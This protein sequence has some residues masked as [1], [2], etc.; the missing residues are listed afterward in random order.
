M[1]IL[2][3]TDHLLLNY[4]KDYGIGDFM[5]RLRQRPHVT[6]KLTAAFEVLLDVIKKESNSN[7]GV[8]DLIEL[9]LAPADSSDI[10][11]AMKMLEQVSDPE[12]SD[13]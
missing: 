12:D 1:S 7:H 2:S 8:E 6:E 9:S 11:E 10:A 3:A 5:S 4:D 13:E